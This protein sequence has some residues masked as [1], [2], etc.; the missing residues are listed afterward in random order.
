M[1]SILEGRLNPEDEISL[2]SNRIELL[3]PHAKSPEAPNP[4][5]CRIPGT[6]KCDGTKSMH[7]GVCGCCLRALFTCSLAEF[8]IML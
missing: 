4:G 5:L 2:A 7:A 6:V 8:A 3:K 1:S